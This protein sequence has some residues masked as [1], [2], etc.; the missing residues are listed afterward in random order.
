MDGYDFEAEYKRLKDSNPDFENI[1]EKMREVIAEEMPYQEDDVNSN[2]EIF[3]RGYQAVKKAHFNRFD[4][5]LAER[6]RRGDIDAS[7]EMLIKAGIIDSLK[8]K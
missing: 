8:E 5:D 1:R 2:H 7:A 3:L 4:P 6:S